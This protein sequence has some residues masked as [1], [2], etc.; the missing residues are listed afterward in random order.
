MDDK[1]Q[2]YRISFQTGNT[3][4]EIESSDK[5]WVESKEKEYL[6][7]IQNREKKLPKT[8]EDSKVEMEKNVTY[9]DLSINEF[10][11]KFI[12]GKKITSRPN[13]AI[14][15]VYYLQKI[16]KLDSAKTQDVVQCFGDISYP[17]YN[18]LNMT[19]ILNQG[20]RKGFL[21]Y[22]NNLWTLTLTGEDFVLNTITS[23]K[24]D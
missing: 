17:N 21:N 13:I 9:Q 18:N 10:Y 7:N 4:F 20:K 15:F 22:I 16:K 5:D 24:N 12:K 23:E 8:Q 2:K 6:E 1:Y 14:F 19:D 3:K 11:Q